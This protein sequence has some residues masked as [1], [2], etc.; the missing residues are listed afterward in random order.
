MSKYDDF[1]DLARICMG[2]AQE[3]ASP[4]VREELRRVAKGYQV[5]A[6]QMDGGK[7]PDIGEEWVAASAH[8]DAGCAEGAKVAPM[9]RRS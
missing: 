3:T 2:N 6:A 4:F 9:V 1:V 5:R 8:L 7:F